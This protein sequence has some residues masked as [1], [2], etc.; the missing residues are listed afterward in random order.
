MQHPSILHLV[1]TR[2]KWIAHSAEMVNKTAL[3][4]DSKVFFQTSCSYTTEMLPPR[5]SASSR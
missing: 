1:P 3:I 2:G 4:D 5:G